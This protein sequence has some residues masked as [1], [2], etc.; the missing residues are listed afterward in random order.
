MEPYTPQF[1]KG[2]YHCPAY[3]EDG[4]PNLDKSYKTYV[5]LRE[6]ST[7]ATAEWVGKE[8]D[9]DVYPKT[10]LDIGEAF[11]ETGQSVKQY[12]A[13]IQGHEFIAGYVAYYFTQRKE[14]DEID[15][16]NAQYDGRGYWPPDLAT[17]LVMKYGKEHADK[18]IQDTLEYVE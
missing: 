12:V 15:P 14:G 9:A 3:K 5:A 17:D 4:T 2:V 16:A 1:Y 8:F 18:W 13:S 11:D 10:Y 7:P 6:F